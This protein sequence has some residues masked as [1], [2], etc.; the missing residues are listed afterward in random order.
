M[1]IQQ[2]GRKIKTESIRFLRA[3]SYFSTEY[4]YREY[5]GKLRWPEGFRCSRCASRSAWRIARDR[6]HCTESDLQTS[7]LAGASFQNT[8]EAI[9]PVDANESR[10][11]PL[12]PD[13]PGLLGKC[14]RGDAAYQKHKRRV[15]FGNCP[16]SCLKSSSRR[17]P[18]SEC[19]HRE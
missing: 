3:R 4:A 6:Y 11:E 8:K 9:A 2:R 7:P 17:P 18:G 10:E 5:L 15:S 14:R 1:K 16:P 13:G 19:R 12:R